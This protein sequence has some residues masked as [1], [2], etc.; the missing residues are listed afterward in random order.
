M[1][2]TYSKVKFI[3]ISYGY[4]TQLR[5]LSEKRISKTALACLM[6]CRQ[7]SFDLQVQGH[8]PETCAKEQQRKTQ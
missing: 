3:Y 4:Y 6:K 1:I 7:R 8:S 2:D 5:S